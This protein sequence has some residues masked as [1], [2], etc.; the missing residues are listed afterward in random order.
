MRT[1]TAVFLSAIITLVAFSAA[2]TQ[3]TTVAGKVARPPRTNSTQDA[4]DDL[5][6]QLNILHITGEQFYILSLAKTIGDKY[7][8]GETLMGIAWQESKAGK[9]GPVGDLKAG[10]GRR[11]Y[12]VCQIKVKLARKMLRQ[13]PTL[14]RYSADGFSTDEELIAKLMF[15]K[16]FNLD[17]AAHIL[18][19]FKTAGLDWNEMLETYNLGHVTK[20]PSK[21]KYTR[22][23][24][25][26]IHSKPVS[27]LIN[28][29]KMR[30][31]FTPTRV[32][33]TRIVAPDV[34]ASRV[35][36]IRV[37]RER[38]P[39]YRLVPLNVPE[40]YA[41]Q[42]KIPMKSGRIAVAEHGYT[43]YDTSTHSF[44]P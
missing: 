42:G 35:S 29:P 30:R 41:S 27:A 17:V 24:A 33:P 44:Q 31:T 6:R 5:N 40:E 15:D 11:S 26:N 34:R 36:Y 1:I 2:T 39:D 25:H 7:N 43:V 12:G 14:R 37:N 38:I 18:L 28:A 22:E 32:V 16:T 4:I 23:I 20:H 10:F 21:F 3:A 9:F 13:Y 19:S 8:L